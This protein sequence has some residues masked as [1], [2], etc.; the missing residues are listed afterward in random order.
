MDPPT[1]EEVDLPTKVG[2]N[3]GNGCR[4]QRHPHMDEPYVPSTPVNG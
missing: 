1:L 2:V 4:R 3:E